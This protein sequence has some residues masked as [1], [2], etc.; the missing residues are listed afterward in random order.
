MVGRQAGPLRS[1]K[2]SAGWHGPYDA[3]WNVLKASLKRLFDDLDD[4]VRARVHQHGAIV[5]H[6]IAV[7]AHPVLGRDLVIL[8]AAGRQHG[9]HADLVLVP[10]RGT[11]GGCGVLP[12]AGLLLV[13]EP[14]HD[15][16]TDTPDDR[17]DRP[18]HD[19]TADCPGRGARSRTALS[20]SSEREGQERNTSRSDENAFHDD[21][22][23]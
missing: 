13:R 22:S 4:A 3:A 2:E 5:D 17:A 10:V 11:A 1:S 9:A 20:I 18:A 6:R 21:H 16:A 15:G 19:C 8:D 14:A 12:E 23:S 7:I